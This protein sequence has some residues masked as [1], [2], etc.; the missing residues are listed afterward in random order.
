MNR[1]VGRWALLLAC[2]LFALLGQYYFAKRPEFFWDGVVFYAISAF[3]LVWLGR[4]P[5]A[6]S[7][8]LSGKPGRTRGEWA[9]LG[10]TGAGL[11]LGA[12]AVFQLR[13]PP[14]DY[15]P[16]FWTWLAGILFCLVATL[17]GLTDGWAGFRGA[18]RGIG[19]W[20]VLAVLALAVLALALRGW[21]IDTIPWTVG[22][23]EGSQGLWARD[24]IAGR[25]PNMFGLGWLSVPNMSFYWQAAWFRVLGDDLVGLRMPWAVVGSATV[26]GTYLLVRRLFDRPLALLTAFLLAVYNYH[27]HYSRLGSNQIADPLFTVWALYFMVVGLQS[28]RAWPWAV[29]GIISGLAFYFYAGS[30]QV[31]VIIVAALLSIAITDMARLRE[32]R[33]GL[34][35]MIVLFLVTVGPMALNAIQSPNDFNAR[36]NAVGIFQSGWLDR[37]VEI[38]GRSKTA[39]L[40]DQVRKAFGAFN[41]YP[42]RVVWYGATIPLLD[43]LASIFFVLGAVLGVLRLRQWRYGIFVLWFV[44][45]IGIG[46]ALTENPPS[47]QRLV[48]S[49]VPVVFFIAVAIV[50]FVEIFG[51]LTNSGRPARL[52]LGGAL[53]II[54]SVTGLRY[55]FGTYQNSW[56]YGSF[57]GEVATRLGYYLRELGPSYEEY[58]FGAPRM[59][60]EFG[61][62][63]FIAKDVPIYDV[64][65]PFSGTALDF[66]NPDRKA[67]FVFLPERIGELDLVR[68][69]APGG[70]VEE[71]RRIPGDWSRPILFT[72]YRVDHR[73][74][75]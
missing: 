61:S 51:S 5:G 47:S 3:C 44:L 74:I 75:H 36:I 17:P 31:P 19:L 26:I 71:V 40:L 15:W 16:A 43:F 23:D 33:A 34:L 53:A 7:A 60:A 66:V 56:I 21:K 27:I 29:S 18:M 45:V 25:S 8:E 20:E 46:G 42:D 52:V 72:A 6:P 32:R 14:Q 1:S 54:L 38:T 10:L 28:K 62:T 35:A 4:L 30:R 2:L 68:Q 37:E 22:G 11:L 9:R 41:I 24:V 69:L 70:T 73:G 50:Q 65:E 67:V 13:E 59:W 48:S 12:V 57:N 64:K 55:Y 39:L 63:P 49:T 58:F